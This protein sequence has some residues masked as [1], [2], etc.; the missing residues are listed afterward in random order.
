MRNL[1]ALH[2]LAA[3]TSLSLFIGTL[4]LIVGMVGH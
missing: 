3:L 1:S 4:L 2:E